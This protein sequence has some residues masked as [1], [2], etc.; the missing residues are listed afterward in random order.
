MNTIQ[1]IAANRS[2]PPN[3]IR[4]V[5]RIQKKTNARDPIT[6]KNEAIEERMSFLIVFNGRVSPYLD[7]VSSSLAITSPRD[8]REPVS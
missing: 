8:G 5:P 1:T 2:C 4:T 6:A 3:T 7:L